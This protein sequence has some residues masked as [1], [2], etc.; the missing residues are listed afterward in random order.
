MKNLGKIDRMIRI[1]VALAV[2][3]LYY[4]DILPGLWGISAAALASIFLIT[5]LVSFCPLYSV[6]G[7]NTHNKKG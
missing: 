1:I 7:V 6:I 2:V 5:S 3:S 4:T